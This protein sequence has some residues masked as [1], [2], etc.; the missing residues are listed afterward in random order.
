MK[1]AGAILSGILAT[2]LLMPATPAS[3]AS[4][5]NVLLIFTDD[6]GQWAV[7]SY[8]NEEVHTPNM[9]RLATEGMRFTRGFTKPVCSPSRAML[10]TGL[11]SHRVGIPDFIPHGNPVVSGN[12]LPPGTPTIASILKKEGYDTALVG[13]WHLG[14]GGRYLPERFGFD[15]AEG[16]RYIAP[17]REIDSVGKIPFL[18]AGEEVERFRHD[19]NHTD[20]LADRAIEFLQADR[21][22]RP[23]FL[24]LSI[25]LPHLPWDAVKE[26]DRAHYEGRE[27]DVGDATGDP[28]K[29]RELR[30]EYYANI[31]CADRNIGRVLEAIDDLGLTDDT[32]VFFIG[33]N[34][35]N[36]GQHGL[37][38]KGNARDLENV[39]RR[40][41]ML[42]H[43]VLVPF[44]VR[45]PGVV[46]PGSVSD[47]IVATIDV[48]PTLSG[49][50]G[51]PDAV[52][53]DGRSLLPILRGETPADWRDAWLDNYD[54]RYLKPDHMRM[55]RT[56]HW[57]LV[58]HSTAG[59]ELFDLKN[60]PEE[61]ENLYS[62]PEVEKVQDELEARLERWI[63]EVGLE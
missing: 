39:E 18:V 7:G 33:D 9:D 29:V 55:I 62:R 56:N 21:R 23:F 24:F 51:Q 43:S 54:M 14:Y 26:E 36:V 32:L 46:E 60:D 19:P 25:Y 30:R 22:G 10:L 61:M 3:E 35:F 27:L 50:V 59:H 11:Y 49:I 42:D 20:V 40:P 28:G 53:T 47:A 13:K 45:W 2:L 58:T 12:G 44:L 34:G 63:K 8:G 1:P 37:L 48:L 6:H 15:V 4:R 17:G 38:G 31:S 16:F 41:N 52:R 5:P 57:K